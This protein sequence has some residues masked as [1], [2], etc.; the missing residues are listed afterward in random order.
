METL[1]EQLKDRTIDKDN[2]YTITVNNGYEEKNLDVKIINFNNRYNNCVV[3][4]L[5]DLQPGQMRNT[6]ISIDHITDI[7]E[8]GGPILKGGRRR[9]KS[10]KRSCKRRKRS[11][12]RRRRKSYRKH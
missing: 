9:R 6:A 10:C 7:Q 12:K 11:C 5:G 1:L 3:E 2:Y 8:I 4:V